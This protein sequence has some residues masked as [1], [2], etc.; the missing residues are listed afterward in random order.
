MTYGVSL[1][2]Q[3]NCGWAA[4]ALGSVSDVWDLRPGPGKWCG[5]TPPREF[6]AWTTLEGWGHCK[7]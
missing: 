7:D 3:E 4:R 6:Q 1:F 5:S 2:P